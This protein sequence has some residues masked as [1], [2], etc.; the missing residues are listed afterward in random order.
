MINF[1][2]GG[3]PRPSAR[4][5]TTSPT[6]IAA[7]GSAADPD[8]RTQLYSD[9]NALL[10]EHIPMVPIAYGGSAIAYKAE[11]RGSQRQ[12][13]QQREHLC[14]GR[15]PD[16]DQ[17]V[18]PAGGEPSGLYRPDET[19]ASARRACAS[20]SPSRSWLYEIGGTAVRPVVR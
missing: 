9:V 1:G 13:A 5:S 19:V 11:C 4:S 7:A 8:E 14:D 15:S 16:Q 20:S 12:P 10:Q 6:Q 3:V 18:F 2:P 17:F